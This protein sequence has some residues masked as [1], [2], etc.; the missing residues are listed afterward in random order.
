MK[1]LTLVVLCVCF[2]IAAPAQKANRKTMIAGL[3]QLKKDMLSDS[4]EKAMVYFKFPLSP[5]ILHAYFA[6]IDTTSDA[7]K[8]TRAFFKKNYTC[9]L[10]K[11][12]FQSLK[13]LSFKQLETKN[14][15]KNEVIP[16]EDTQPS[17]FSYSVQLKG[18]EIAI[19]YLLNANPLYKRKSGEDED[20][21]E[22]GIWWVLKFKNGQWWFTSIEAAG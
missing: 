20:P 3:L 6:D 21:P 9:I 14:A 22:Y 15:I 11:E 10:N 1:Y 13:M 17:M 4:A 8:T 5:K 16:K 7:E 2:F 12:F 19:S 18:D